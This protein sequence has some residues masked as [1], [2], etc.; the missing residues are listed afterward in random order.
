MD[1]KKEIVEMVEK[2]T[3]KENIEMLYGATKTMLE[4]EENEEEQGN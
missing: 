1:Y 2:I 4:Y 3:K